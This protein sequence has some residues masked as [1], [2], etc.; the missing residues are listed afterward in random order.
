MIAG[1]VKEVF[2]DLDAA[3]GSGGDTSSFFGRSCFL[4]LFRLGATGV[5]FASA[6]DGGAA[7]VAGVADVDAVGS[8]SDIAAAGAIV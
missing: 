3:A 2:V 8:V 4:W 1:C 5:G 7:V 6:V